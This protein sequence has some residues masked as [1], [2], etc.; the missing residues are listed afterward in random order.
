MNKLIALIYFALSLYGCDVGG[1]T[2]VHRTRVNGADAL[3]SKATVQAGVAR[4]ECLRSVSG[5]CYYTVLPRD[6]AHAPGST[7]ARNVR[8]RPEPIE[9]FALAADDSRQIPGLQGFRLCV[10]THAASAGPGACEMPRPI[11]AR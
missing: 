5:R 11:A 9:R 4:F 8:C 1:S 7:H 2:Y 10:G 6:C 3:Y